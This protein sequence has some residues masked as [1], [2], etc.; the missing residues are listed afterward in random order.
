M[1]EQSSTVVLLRALVMLLCL[2]MIPVAAL[3]GTAIPNVFKA[4]QSGRLP[5]LAELRGTP[6][7]TVSPFPGASNE[8]PRYVSSDGTGA[9][10]GGNVAPPW[11]GNSAN[12]SE[13]SSPL[14]Q[15]W[16]SPS[17]AS[18]GPANEARASNPAGNYAGGNSTD[19]MPASYNLPVDAHLAGQ[20]PGMSA[21]TRNPLAAAP[22]VANLTPM[23]RG[24]AGS[25]NAS[26]RASAAADPFTYVHNR[27]IALGATY[28]VLESL[29]DQKREYRFLCKMAVGGSDQFTKAFWCVDADP[30]S[31]MMNVLKQVEGWRGGGG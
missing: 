10:A 19:V 25:A 18:I 26:G 28:Y 9:V 7:A 11:K 20:N 1:A 14:A 21:N 17:A 6:P 23:D 15:R 16:S 2:I 27:L 22:G 13:T 4:L 3:F 12:T 8:A 5:T 30:K 29:G 24:P 31:A